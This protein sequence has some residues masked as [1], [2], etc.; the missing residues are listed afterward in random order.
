MADSRTNRTNRS[1]P[2]GTRSEGDVREADGGVAGPR[3]VDSPPAVSEPGDEEDRYVA[4][5]GGEAARAPSFEAAYPATYGTPKRDRLKR[6]YWAYV[7]GHDRGW[8]AERKSETAARLVEE[9]ERARR[10]RRWSRR[11]AEEGPEAPAG[12]V[13]GTR[14]ETPGA[15]IGE[16][17]FGVP[18]PRRLDYH[19]GPDTWR[20]R[21]RLGGGARRRGAV[22]R[23][24]VQERDSDRRDAGDGGA[25][26]G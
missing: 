2:H 10:G 23:R 12:M 6:A 5:K 22:P 19:R 9:E 17:R 15:P 1:D 4:L 25:D 20:D 24:G 11:G 18:V 8:E 21:I 3:V 13:E 7:M 14:D 26:G 16:A